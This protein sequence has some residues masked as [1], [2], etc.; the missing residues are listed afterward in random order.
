MI[1]TI[2][3]HL[4]QR[5]RQQAYCPFV[6]QFAQL[7]RDSRADS[8]AEIGAEAETELADLR[9]Q[10]LSQLKGKIQWPVIPAILDQLDK[11]LSSPDATSAQIA[12]VVMTDPS[13]TVRVLNLINS[14][15]YS[16]I[17][18]IDEVEQAV[19]LLGAEQIRNATV[20]ASVV[21]SFKGQ[22]GFDSE[23]FW[24][25]SMGV[26]LASRLIGKVLKDKGGQ[27]ATEGAFLAGLLH[28]IG[29]IVIV[30]QLPQQHL[31]IQAAQETGVDLLDA[32]LA[33]TGTRHTEL[34]RDLLTEW[35]LS[36]DIASAAGGHHDP[37]DQGMYPHIIHCAD[38]IA[39]GLGYGYKGQAFP[40][41]HPRAW[42]TLGLTNQSI[43]SIA[44]KL[45]EQIDDLI[46]S[47]LR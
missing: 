1:S 23:S 30:Q 38:A 43:R 41:M 7:M 14:P 39:H 11:V 29:R 40:R 6:N 45:A 27:T 24:I 16:L 37:V 3:Q 46:E 36:D 42:Q 19:S 2:D 15:A 22:N 21:S 28:D 32:E 26:A 25:H 47:M 18:T 20:A 8:Q 13:L 17:R 44:S 33:F 12:E 31:Q 34:G 35:S 4:E 9:Q 10:T 5:F